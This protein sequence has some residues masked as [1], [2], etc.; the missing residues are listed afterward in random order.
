[1]SPQLV[2]TVY[3][4]HISE[5]PRDFWYEEYIDP[6]YGDTAK[7]YI[8]KHCMAKH[9]IKVTK[10]FILQR[11]PKIKQYFAQ[12]CKIENRWERNIRKWN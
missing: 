4:Q 10:I 12:L 11:T 7:D 6:F 3:L 2:Q 5:L 8:L 9:N 1:M